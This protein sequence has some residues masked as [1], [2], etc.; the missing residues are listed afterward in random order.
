MATRSAAPAKPPAYDI[1]FIW[2]DNPRVAW[3]IE[4]KVV[5]TPGTLAPGVSHR[6]MLTT[7]ALPCF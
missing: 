5:P 6:W 1:A 2:H 7:I 4:A 3:P